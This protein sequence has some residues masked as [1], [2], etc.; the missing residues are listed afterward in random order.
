M[1]AALYPGFVAH[2][3]RVKQPLREVTYQNAQFSGFFG[4]KGPLTDWQEALIL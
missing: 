1:G 4:K 3:Y 2:E